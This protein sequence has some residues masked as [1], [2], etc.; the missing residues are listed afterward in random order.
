MSNNNGLNLGQLIKCLDE[1]PE[2]TTV[3]FDFGYFSPKGYHS[4]RGHYEDLGLGYEHGNHN[5]KAKDYAKELHSYIGQTIEG[6]KGGAYVVT[7][8]TGLWVSGSS[9]ECTGTTIFNVRDLGY[10][11]AIIE[12]RYEE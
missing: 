8:K 2:E 7:A 9:R 12:T 6:Y 11:S 5:L 4:Y 10:D 1:L 3:R